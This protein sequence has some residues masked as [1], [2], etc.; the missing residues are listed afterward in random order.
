M[1]KIHACYETMSS[2]MLCRLAWS[3]DWVSSLPTLRWTPLIAV[4]PDPVTAPN[5]SYWLWITSDTYPVCSSVE[6]VALSVGREPVPVIPHWV[7]L[8]RTYLPYVFSAD[9]RYR[10]HNSAGALFSEDPQLSLKRK[11]QTTSTR[12]VWSSRLVRIRVSCS[13]MW[14]P[15]N[16]AGSTCTF[17]AQSQFNTPKFR[18]A[19]N[20]MTRRA[21]HYVMLLHILRRSQDGRPGA[22]HLSWLFQHRAALLTL[23]VSVHV[24]IG[25]GWNVGQLENQELNP[26]TPP[27]LHGPMSDAFIFFP[28]TQQTKTCCFL[29]P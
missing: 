2:L 4:T 6:V 14:R 29:K 3:C 27:P 17:W 24:A 16:L 20:R 10:G 1:L 11:K 26:P 5:S 19:S 28:N 18:T 22:K 25:K 23:F 13:A 7:V 12:A 8:V 15:S 9:G 21:N